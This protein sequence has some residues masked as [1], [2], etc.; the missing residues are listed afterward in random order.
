MTHH[1]TN[2]TGDLADHKATYRG[3][4]LLV[5]ISAAV[6]LISLGLIYFLLAH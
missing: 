6:S 5:K 2:A 4:L 1:C 3:F